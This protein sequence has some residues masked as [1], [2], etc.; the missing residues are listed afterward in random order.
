MTRGD[1]FQLQ[2]H[3][4]LLHPRIRT[5]T[6]FVDLYRPLWNRRPAAHSPLVCVCS[7]SLPLA[8]SPNFSEWLIISLAEPDNSVKFFCKIAPIERVFNRQAILGA[9]VGQ[10]LGRISE[11]ARSL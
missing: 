8:S 11:L 1:Y 4:G 9:E 7:A 10:P 2:L 6:D 5:S 3:R